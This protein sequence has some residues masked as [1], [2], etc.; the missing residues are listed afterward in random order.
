MDFTGLLCNFAMFVPP[1]F[2][3]TYVTAYLALFYSFYKPIES[4]RDDIRKQ[5]SNAWANKYKTFAA[6]VDNI[7]IKYFRVLK[8]PTPK[9]DRP[10]RIFQGIFGLVSFILFF[11]GIIV[12]SIK[13]PNIWLVLG[14][15]IGM[16]IYIILFTVLICRS[17]L[18]LRFYHFLDTLDKDTKAN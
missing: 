8:K 6:I 5:V 10:F 14:L 15:F 16:V 2:A 13:E 11:F 12:N 1:A 4:K 17:W 3:A 18:E 7:E 9:E